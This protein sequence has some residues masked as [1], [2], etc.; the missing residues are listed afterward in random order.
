MFDSSKSKALKTEDYVALFQ[1]MGVKCTVIANDE[2]GRWFM[3]ENP[4][5]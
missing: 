4:A 1:K 3:F 2:E 5:E